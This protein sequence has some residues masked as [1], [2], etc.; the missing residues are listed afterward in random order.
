MYRKTIN[1]VF[2]Y[3]GALLA[4]CIPLSHKITALAIALFVF[5]WLL[6]GEWIKN[7]QVVLKN[8]FFIIGILFFLIHLIGLIYSDNKPVGWFDIEVKLSLLLFPLVFLMSSVLIENKKLI[9]SIFVIGNIMA[10]LICLGTA[11]YNLYFKNINTFSYSGL[12][13]IHHPAYFALYLCFS[14]AIILCQ[15]YSKEQLLYVSSKTV[16][17]FILVLFSIMIYM[18]SSKAGIIS[19]FITL[20]LLSVLALKNK[21][22]RKI[23]IVIILL[24][25]FQLW[26]SLT[27]NIRFQTV[28]TSVVTAESH[29]QTEESNAVRVLVWETTIDI[30]KTNYVMG[31]GTGDIKDV[32]M[33]KYKERNMIGALENKLNVH[34][35]FLETW[36]G[37]GIAGIT[38]LLLLFLLPLIVSIR[39]KDWLLLIFIVL[40]GFNFLFESMLNTQAGVVFFGFFYYYLASLNIKKRK[41]N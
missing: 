18:L 39:N 1:Q 21:S 32:L 24:A 4:F 14:S 28:T 12:S 33:N 17:V 40:M 29:M 7:T 23:A 5:S 9:F 35:Q 15:F 2:V 20:V 26:F 19:F 30:L 37:Q 27:Q 31:V 36:L 8:S 22:N 38:L 13:V 3:S 41:I 10:V 34:N 6:S 11:F 25:G 16:L